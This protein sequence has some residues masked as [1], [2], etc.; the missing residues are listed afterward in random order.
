M[1]AAETQGAGMAGMKRKHP[2]KRK[3]KKSKKSGKKLKTKDCSKTKSSW[4]PSNPGIF[5]KYNL[6]DLNIP[7]EAMPQVS[8]LNGGHHGYTLVADNGAAFWF[9]IKKLS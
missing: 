6:D 3:G 4:K 7:E 9:E 5:G 8:Q 2:K 1:K